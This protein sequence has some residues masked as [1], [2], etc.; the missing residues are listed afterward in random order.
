MGHRGSVRRHAVTVTVVL[1]GCLV[2]AL[3]VGIWNLV[4]TQE[5]VT[6]VQLAPGA[7]RVARLVPAPA[8]ATTLR[9]DE[10]E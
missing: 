2:A 4:D 3:V 10:G 8:G 1:V 5:P 7:D 6:P 9:S